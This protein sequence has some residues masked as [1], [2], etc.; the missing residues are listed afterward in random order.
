MRNSDVGDIAIDFGY[1]ITYRLSRRS[2][3][4]LVVVDF[5]GRCMCLV[6]A[7]QRLCLQPHALAV[8][9]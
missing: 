6:C 2:N 4:K 5:Y 8:Q 1:F 9:L 7:L 3:S